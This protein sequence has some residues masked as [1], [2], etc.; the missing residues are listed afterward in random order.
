MGGRGSVSSIG[1]EP[2]SKMGA[3]IFYNAAKKSDAL[4]GSGTVKKDSKLERGAQSGQLDFIDKINGVKEATRVSHYYTD[5][6]N[7][8]QRQIA[9]LGSADALYKNQKLAREY[10]NILS[11]SV[12][13]SDKMHEYSKPIEK[14]NTDAYHDPSRTTT[15]YDRARKR[16]MSNF[17]AWF[18][19]SGKKK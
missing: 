12:K 4:R 15:T 3:K 2:V 5:R 16:R 10:K 8:L 1:G 13:I 18:Y 7:E 9:K 11:A 14:G 6:L 19:G 17:E